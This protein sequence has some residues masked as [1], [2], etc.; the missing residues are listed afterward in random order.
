MTKK[1]KNQLQILAFMNQVA[2]TRGKKPMDR[3]EALHIDIV[4]ISEGKEPIK[5]KELV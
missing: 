1:E 4:R 2:G 5:M 3:L